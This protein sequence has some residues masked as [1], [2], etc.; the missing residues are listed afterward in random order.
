M[1]PKRKRRGRRRRRLKHT[2]PK[3]EGAWGGLVPDYP[4]QIPG[5]GYADLVY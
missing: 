1:W 4:Y 2:P 5:V 3:P